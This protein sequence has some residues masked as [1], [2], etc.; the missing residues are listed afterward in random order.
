MIAM[1]VALTALSSCA[2]SPVDSPPASPAA[3][4]TIANGTASLHLPIDAYMLPPVESVPF[5][6]LR[7]AV[8]ADYMRR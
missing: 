7:R 6:R 1:L 2:S 4:P 3:T 5:D 8:T